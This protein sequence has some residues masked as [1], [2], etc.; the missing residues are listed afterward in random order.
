MQPRPSLPPPAGRP[1]APPGQ[2][3]AAPAATPPQLG[4][5]HRA[6]RR[7]PG[8]WRRESGRPS[9]PRARRF[10]R[11]P[12]GELGTH[13]DSCSVARRPR[14][15]QRPGQGSSSAAAAAAASSQARRSL[16]RD[17]ASVRSSRAAR[18]VTD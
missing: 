16:P 17:A 14:L 7:A 6:R 13:R 15:P 3:H 1:A 8:K 10:P 9:Q 11:Q 4:R 5:P 2:V 12:E 18:S